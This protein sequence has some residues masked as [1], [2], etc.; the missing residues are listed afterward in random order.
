M[1][2]RSRYGYRIRN[3]SHV[4]APSCSGVVQSSE[5]FP[6]TDLGA[7]LPQSADHI[8]QRTR[9]PGGPPRR[10]SPGTRFLSSSSDCSK[11]F[12]TTATSLRTR[13]SRRIN[14][15]YWRTADAKEKNCWTG[16]FRLL[17]VS[18]SWNEHHRSTTLVARRSFSD[19]SISRSFCI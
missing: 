2:H 4:K 16:Y 18:A 13:R 7:R 17:S 14:S 8:Q 3:Y 6:S 5:V 11:P 15:V 1:T 10:V 19:F 9:T 12:I